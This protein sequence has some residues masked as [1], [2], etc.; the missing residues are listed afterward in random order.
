MLTT[1]PP[2]EPRTSPRRSPRRERGW[3]CAAA[4]LF[5]IWAPSLAPA[6]HVADRIIAVVNSDVITLSEL[7]TEIAPEEA[8]LRERY[9]GA[10]LDRRLRQ[11]EYVGLTR[12]IER[13]LQMQAARVKGVDV[14]DE[15][16]TAAVSEMKRQGEKIDESNP[17][18]RQYIKEQLTLMK[19]VDREVRSGVMVSSAEMTRYYDSHRSRFMLP[20]EYRISQ[21]LIQPRSGES[22]AE[23]RKKA[24]EVRAA[25][26]QG[27]E[28]GE[29][30]LRHSSGTEAARGGGLGI[31][32]QGE[33]LPPIERALAV[34]NP[35]QVSQPIETPLGLHI[36]RVDEKKP[37]Q[38]RPFSEVKAENQHLVTQH[39]SEDVYQAWIGELKDKA[40]INI[41]LF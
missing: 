26:Q 8:R 38:F 18:E 2:S 28:F 17:R 10:E 22:I 25:V 15:E 1:R 39:K 21:I 30:A 7:K 36:I 24:A 3:L 29:L 40:Y 4:I 12:M 16:L 32:R 27:Q 37:A 34:L 9:R 11:L 19:V 13:R 31:V 5:T 6:A 41:K 35:G 14:T 20:D 23:A 33:L